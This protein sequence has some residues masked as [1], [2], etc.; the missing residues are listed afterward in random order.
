VARSSSHNLRGQRDHPLF[1]RLREGMA[2][3]FEPT[4]VADRDTAV[5]DVHA[6]GYGRQ[7]NMTETA[8][9][10]A[11][12]PK[13]LLPAAICRQ[14][15]T[16][17]ATAAA[18]GTAPH[19]CCRRHRRHRRRRWHGGGVGVSLGKPCPSGRVELC[20]CSARHRRWVVAAPELGGVAAV[21][22]FQQHCRSSGGGCEPRC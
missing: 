14:Q 22:S 19:P 11:G 13:S 7:G 10:V 18:G 5:K 6:A 1:R 4:A 21:W 9:I 20:A 16:T 3:A 15:S 8:G 12:S 2:R 17:T